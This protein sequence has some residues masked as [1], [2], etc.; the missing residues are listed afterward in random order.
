MVGLLDPIQNFLSQRPDPSVRSGVFSAMEPATISCTQHEEST[1]IFDPFAPGER[2]KTCSFEV[3]TYADLERW[4]S[5]VIERVTPITPA[6]RLTPF[7]AIQFNLPELAVEI[8]GVGKELFAGLSRLETLS[9][10][11]DIISAN[12]QPYTG[13]FAY[14]NSSVHGRRSLARR[15]A[16]IAKRKLNKRSLYNPLREL[17]AI[18]PED[19]VQQEVSHR[20][21]FNELREEVAAWIETRRAALNTPETLAARA[22]AAAPRRRTAKSG[23]GQKMGKRSQDDAP[24]RKTGH[25]P[26]A[27]PSTKRFMLSSGFTAHEGVLGLFGI[28]SP[29]RVAA[30]RQNGAAR[31]DL[32]SSSLAFVA[33]LAATQLVA[34]TN[35]WLIKHA[36]DALTACVLGPVI[37]E[38]AKVLPFVGLL[39]GATE[40]ASIYRA[41]PSQEKSFSLLHTAFHLIVNPHVVRTITG[42]L[43]RQWS[44]KACIATSSLIHMAV[45]T[46][47]TLAASPAGKIEETIL[48][49]PLPEEP[50]QCEEAAF[51]PPADP[52]PRTRQATAAWR[53][54]PPPGAQATSSESDSTTGEPNLSSGEC[55][56]SWDASATSSSS[57]SPSGFQENAGYRGSVSAPKQIGSR[58]MI[59]RPPLADILHYTH[60]GPSF[61]TKRSMLD[62]FVNSAGSHGSGTDPCPPI[63]QHPALANPAHDPTTKTEAAASETETM[64]MNEEDI[65]REARSR[66]LPPFLVAH[67][68]HKRLHKKLMQFKKRVGEGHFREAERA[69][70]NPALIHRIQTAA[71]K[72]PSDFASFVSKAASISKWMEARKEAKNLLH[73]HPL[74]GDP[75]MMQT[76][77]LLG[78]IIDDLTPGA[79]HDDSRSE[80]ATEAKPREHQFLEQ[81]WFQPARHEK[82]WDKC[83]ELVHNHWSG[84]ASPQDDEATDM[85]PRSRA[86]SF[87]NHWTLN[88]AATQARSSVYEENPE[89]PL[90]KA[91]KH[92]AGPARC[93]ITSNQL[94]L[95]SLGVAAAAYITSKASTFIRYFVERSIDRAALAYS[96]NLGAFIQL[97]DAARNRAPLQFEADICER[98]NVAMVHNAFE[99]RALFL[100][101]GAHGADRPVLLVVASR[102]R[103]GLF[104]TCANPTS[105][106]QQLLFCAN[107]ILAGRDL[108]IY[109]LN[110]FIK[111]KGQDGIELAN[112]SSRRANAQDLIACGQLHHITRESLQ[113]ANVSV[114]LGHINNAPFRSV[115]ADHP[116]Q[117]VAHSLAT[118]QSCS[119]NLNPTSM[120]AV[121]TNTL[122]V[123]LQSIRNDL[124]S[125]AAIHTST[126]M[127]PNSTNQRIPATLSLSALGI[128]A[129]NPRLVTSLFFITQQLQF[130]AKPLCLL[131]LTH[132]I[133]EISCT[134]FTAGLL[135]A[136]LSKI[137][138]SIAPFLNSLAT[139]FEK[140]R[141]SIPKSTPFCLVSSSNTAPNQSATKTTSSAEQDTTS[142]QA[143][144]SNRTRPSS[145][146]NHTQWNTTQRCR[147]VLLQRTPVPFS[148]LMTLLKQF[149]CQLSTKLMNVFFPADGS[150]KRSQSWSAPNTSS[151]ILSPAPWQLGTTRPSKPTT[152]DSSSPSS[153]NSSDTSPPT[154][155]TTTRSRNTSSASFED[156]MPA[157][158]RTS[159]RHSKKDSA[160]G[161]RGRQPSTP[162]STSQSP[163]DAHSS[164]RGKQRRKCAKNSTTSA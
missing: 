133:Q 130:T 73:T 152:T 160:A 96:L 65:H 112:I 158:T 131:L 125:L 118:N 103:E 154:T 51:V 134:L 97:N 41:D 127:T 36:G 60:F 121:D 22:A 104:Q 26:G 38:S 25:K 67:H 78:G 81:G 86:D 5:V 100:T 79:A 1:G 135:S 116:A 89:P 145:N 161:S 94:C 21:A 102:T 149:C 47:L 13:S 159:A 17:K 93:M 136:C 30:L 95:A 137:M 52:R 111:L 6:V 59:S 24:T 7:S 141:S 62:W 39:I 107:S 63:H 87:L 75:P 37:E 115:N 108:Y 138:P 32:T 92:A 150:S 88:G 85:E 122:L 57:E 155:E 4:L 99:G 58:F 14:L 77:P 54:W 2:D 113:T 61:N 43:G 44:W 117:M 28:I 72:I 123:I 80:S 64:I 119:S 3:P 83:I 50:T 147:L 40:D 18:D 146:T 56:E 70:R 142:G 82:A 132:G 31:F 156:K 157:R 11:H 66:D 162:S 46:A 74:P 12:T 27:H 29:S 16:D 10:A 144:P 45:N 109:A 84:G 15:M 148:A 128:A 53:S 101:Q 124:N 23:D 71:K 114:Q 42:H 20:A 110:T 55:S 106:L 19:A 153:K 35:T 8:A 140:F 48:A 91:T 120:M 105:P 76:L 9:R 126:D 164:A 98:D 143:N 69:A 49:P 139:L 34:S 90:L 33:G 68:E 163:Q 129:S 151:T